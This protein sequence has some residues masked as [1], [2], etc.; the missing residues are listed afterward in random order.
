[1]SQVVLIQQVS[2]SVRMAQNIQ[3]TNISECSNKSMAISEKYNIILGKY[4]LQS[5]HQ[6]LVICRGYVDALLLMASKA[7]EGKRYCIGSGNQ[8]NNLN[9]FKK[10]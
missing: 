3:V 5:K 1:M 6:R 10:N 7:K 9:L 2:S 8:I 4:Y